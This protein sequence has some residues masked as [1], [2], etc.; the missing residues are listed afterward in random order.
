MFSVLTDVLTAALLVL[1]LKLP[2]VSNELMVS[3]ATGSP[4]LVPLLGVPS[5]TRLPAFPRLSEVLV[6]TVP[7]FICTVPV[8]G[9][10]PLRLSV[11]PPVVSPALPVIGALML[12]LTPAAKLRLA[13][14]IR[15]SALLPLA[16]MA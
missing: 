1:H 7:L 11:P 14:L 9:L 13:P 2:I 8:K 12:A 4:V 10:W 15:F 5:E 16:A 3:A 6:M